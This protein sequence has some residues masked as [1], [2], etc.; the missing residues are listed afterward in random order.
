[1]NRNTTISEIAAFLA[2]QYAA[3]AA[4]S[5]EKAAGNDRLTEPIL[6]RPDHTSEVGQPQAL[7]ASRPS[8]ADLSKDKDRGEL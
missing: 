3:S 7:D 5:V 6:P 8:D 2:A 1:M 4:P